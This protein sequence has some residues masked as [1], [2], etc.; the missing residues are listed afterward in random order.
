[1]RK[2]ED[3]GEKKDEKACKMLEEVCPAIREQSF[4]E[5]TALCAEEAQEGKY[6]S[7]EIGIGALLP[8]YSDTPGNS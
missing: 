8:S 7:L 2:C 3:G 5:I 4:D 6:Q 1:M